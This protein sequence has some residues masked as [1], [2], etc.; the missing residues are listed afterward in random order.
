MAPPDALIL[1]SGLNQQGLFEGKGGRLNR[2]G[3]AQGLFKIDAR[4][5]GHATPPRDGW[6]CN[7][8]FRASLARWMR[9]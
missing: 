9:L 6:D 3:L 7:R 4:G 1:G 8:V 2:K 5:F